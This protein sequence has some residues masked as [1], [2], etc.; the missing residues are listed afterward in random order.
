ME[1]WIFNSKF[2]NEGTYNHNGEEVKIISKNGM[3]VTIEFADGTQA[4]V[5]ATE[6]QKQ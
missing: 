4:E 1:K 5:Y 2:C 3:F 6:V